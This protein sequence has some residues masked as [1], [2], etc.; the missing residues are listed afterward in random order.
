MAAI[1]IYERALSYLKECF[2]FKNSPFRT[3]SC[4][5]LQKEVTFD[6]LVACFKK[7]EVTFDGD[8]LYEEFA[9]LRRFN[10]K[11][12]CL[13]F[14]EWIIKSAVDSDSCKRRQ[15]KL[16]LSHLSSFLHEILKSP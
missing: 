9:P 6:Q 15:K 2:D 7:L 11:M 14:V 5:S 12:S 4:L 10:F 3:F 16:F 13:E 8:Q 1:K